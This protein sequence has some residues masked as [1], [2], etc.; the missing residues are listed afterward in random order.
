MLNFYPWGLS[1]N[2]VQPQALDRSRVSFRAYV[3]DAGKLGAGAGAA[4]DQVE[5]EDEAV[6]EAV[7]RGVRSHWYHHGRYSPTRERGV[8]HFHRLLCEFMN[9]ER[10]L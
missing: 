1:L 2:L 4:L 9:D 3:W 10:P 7:Q 8:H 5:K 6:V